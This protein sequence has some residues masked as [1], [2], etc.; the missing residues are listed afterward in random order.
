[1]RS[2]AE[3]LCRFGTGVIGAKSHGKLDL[4]FGE[5]MNVGSRF[6]YCLI[7]L[8]AAIKSDF[9]SASNN[10]TTCLSLAKRWLGC[11]RHVALIFCSSDLKDLVL[12]MILSGLTMNFILYEKDYGLAIARLCI[13]CVQTLL[14]RARAEIALFTIPPWLS[15]TVA[16]KVCTQARL[17]IV[18]STFK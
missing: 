13:A 6:Y 17:C 18:V 2:T 4:I 14:R 12:P 9:E 15:F 3:S 11:Y 7:K 16:C 5:M 10:Q 1:M 8:I